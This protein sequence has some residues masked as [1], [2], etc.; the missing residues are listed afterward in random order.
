MSASA[1]PDTFEVQVSIEKNAYEH[2]RT[3][4]KILS[5]T[6]GK[7]SIMT[8]LN[9][10]FTSED[11]ESGVKNQTHTDG[12]EKSS[13]TDEE[14]LKLGSISLKIQQNYGNARDIEFGIKD[15]QIYMLQ[16]RPITNLDSSFTQYELMH[17][18]DTPHMTEYEIYSRAHWG[19]NLPGSGSWISCFFFMNDI[20]F[21]VCEES[22]RDTV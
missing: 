3:V 9:A 17:E 6:L 7:K 14:V 8:K 18:L 2:D 5:K 15:G 20:S 19:E 21:M 16:S 12:S 10:D 4:S 11:L 13:L 22:Y 1:D